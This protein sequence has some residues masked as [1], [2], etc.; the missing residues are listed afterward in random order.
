M[1]TNSPPTA[2]AG[3]PAG[4]PTPTDMTSDNHHVVR[5][6]AQSPP[7][8][9]ASRVTFSVSRGLT[10]PGDPN[11]SFMTTIRVDQAARETQADTRTNVPAAPAASTATNV[12]ATSISC[13]SS[14]TGDTYLT[15]ANTHGTQ[16]GQHITFM[17]GHPSQMATVIQQLAATEPQR[18]GGDV[19]EAV[20]P[21]DGAG[22]T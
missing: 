7:T 18:Q 6:T 9:D 13:E 3:A 14:L 15:D 2:P 8:V 10:L 12:P 5:D 1:D 4:P 21:E 22:S 16:A 17:R 20:S 11:A 19:E